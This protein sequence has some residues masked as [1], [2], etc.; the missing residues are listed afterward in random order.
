MFLKSSH[1]TVLVTQIRS[2]KQGRQKEAVAEAFFQIVIKVMII[3]P[4]D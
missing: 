3:I 4:R 1:I 2:K